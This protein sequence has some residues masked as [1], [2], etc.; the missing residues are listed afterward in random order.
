MLFLL[1]CW[2]SAY[3]EKRDIRNRFHN[4]GLGTGVSRERVRKQSIDID[5]RGIPETE[6]MRDITVHLRQCHRCQ[7]K[8]Q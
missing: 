2:T 4:H 5:I 1:C 8:E 7:R 3:F 6:E